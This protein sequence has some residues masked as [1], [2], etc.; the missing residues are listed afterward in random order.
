MPIIETLFSSEGS[1]EPV[2]T[3]EAKAFAYI[4]TS[5]DDTLIGTLITAARK[6]IEDYCSVSLVTRT[7]TIKTADDNEFYLPNGPLNAITSLQDSDGNNITYTLFG[8]SFPKIKYTAADNDTATLIYTTT[9]D[10]GE[11]YETAIKIIVK[12]WYEH[13][14]ELSNKII[15][16]SIPAT[17]QM[18]VA[19]KRKNLWR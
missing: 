10:T 8:S 4:D 5:D 15:K 7:V 9:A 11:D 17:A 2:T 12:Y 6:Y 18:A 3:A 16:E 13:R 14:G 1:T 19:H